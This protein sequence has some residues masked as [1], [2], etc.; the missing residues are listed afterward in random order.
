MPEETS[1][2][3]DDLVAVDAIIKEIFPQAA[4]M[5]VNNSLI[6]SI[7]YSNQSD[8]TTLID[9]VNSEVKGEGD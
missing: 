8:I 4:A 1:P 3:A 2:T 9:R 7:V 6:A 5:N